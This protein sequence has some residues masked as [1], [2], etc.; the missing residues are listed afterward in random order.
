MLSETLLDIS[1]L[2]TIITAC[3]L[4]LYDVGP[5][6]HGKEEPGAVPGLIAYFGS[7][8][9]TRTYNLVVNRYA[10]PNKHIVISSTSFVTPVANFH[11]R[12]ER[13]IAD[14]HKSGTSL[15]PNDNP[16]KNSGV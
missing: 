10:C 3:T 4:A 13:Y 6:F 15:F 11:D 2:S 7:P 1:R 12:S 14:W 9:R 5:G 16:M 8:S